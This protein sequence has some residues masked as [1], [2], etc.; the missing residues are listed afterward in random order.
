MPYDSRTGTLNTFSS[1]CITCGGS[2][3]DEERIRRRRL[4]ATIS[5]LRGARP[6]IAWCIVGTAVYQVGFV[7]ANHRKNFSASKFGAQAID[8]PAAMLDST[9]PIKPWM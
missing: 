1:S 7:S 8:A 6:R 2:E 3:E 4:A 9:A 5:T